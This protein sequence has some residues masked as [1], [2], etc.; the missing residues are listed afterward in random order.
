MHV[1]RRRLRLALR[2]RINPSERESA[3]YEPKEHGVTLK[4]L[5]PPPKVPMPRWFW[6]AVVTGAVVVLVAMA[7]MG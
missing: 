2:P 1:T 5:D 6:I 4:P 3:F 7:F